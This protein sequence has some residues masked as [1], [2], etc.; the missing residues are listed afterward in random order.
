MNNYYETVSVSVDI[1]ILEKIDDMVQ[2][3]CKKYTQWEKKSK[4]TTQH[5]V[6]TQTV[7]AYTAVAVSTEE[8]ETKKE[9]KT[10]Q[11]WQTDTLE[12][13]RRLTNEDEKKIY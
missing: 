7:G 5:L 11:T 13:E 4:D 9:T 2:I 6:E 10:D 1:E 8:N 3:E 12:E